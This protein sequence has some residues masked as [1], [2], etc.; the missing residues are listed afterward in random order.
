MQSGLYVPVAEYVPG[1]QLCPGTGL[2]QLVMSMFEIKPD[3][4][5]KQSLAPLLA[6]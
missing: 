2:M 6:E 1:V 4:H 3:A 5:D